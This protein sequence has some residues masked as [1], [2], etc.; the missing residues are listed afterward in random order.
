MKQFYIKLR[1]VLLL[2]RMRFSDW[3]FSYIKQPYYLTKLTIQ[4]I[5]RIIYMGVRLWQKYK[6]TDIEQVGRIIKRWTDIDI[7]RTR[8]YTREQRIEISKKYAYLEEK[9]GIPQWRWR[10][11]CEK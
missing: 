8:R 9:T 1:I 4:D 2:L 11:L 6:D 5:L 3:T 10:S 7:I